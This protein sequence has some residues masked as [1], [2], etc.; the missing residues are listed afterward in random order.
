MP[1][2]KPQPQSQSQSE[3]LVEMA[4]TKIFESAREYRTLAKEFLSKA[5]Q[6]EGEALRVAMMIKQQEDEALREAMAEA[7]RK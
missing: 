6:L 2:S 1:D 7:G 4:L 3:Q 5:D